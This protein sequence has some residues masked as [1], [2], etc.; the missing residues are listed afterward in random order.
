[1]R[2]WFEKTLSGARPADA[3][4][5]AV[6]R[7]FKPGTTFEAEV[8]TRQNRS[9]AWHRRYWVLMS[10]IAENIEEIDIGHG[11]MMPIHGGE[12]VHIAVKLLTGHVDTYTTEV[13]GQLH[14]VR[15]PR[16]TN[17]REMSPEDW[18]KYWPK[19]LDAVHQH[20][21]PGI[22]GYVEEEIARLAS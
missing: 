16:P 2:V 9:G 1:M 14:I 4:A 20:I 13:D 12:D 7:K 5:A 3:E 22:G 21:L 6:L 18:A 19:V 8:I 17:F 11:A 10:M 15:I